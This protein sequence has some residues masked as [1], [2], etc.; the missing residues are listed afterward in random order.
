[1]VQVKSTISENISEFKSQEG[2]SKNEFDSHRVLLKKINEH[3]SLIM[4]HNKFRNYLDEYIIYITG[5]PYFD[6]SILNVTLGEL[7]ND[8][9][10]EKTIVNFP[11]VFSEKHLNMSILSLIKA[12]EEITTDLLRI[13]ENYR[14]ISFKISIDTLFKTG[15]LNIDCLLTVARMKDVDLILKVVLH[16][17]SKLDKKMNGLVHKSKKMWTEISLHLK[18]YINTSMTDAPKPNKASFFKEDI[19]D[20]EDIIK[21]MMV[22][23][24]DS[25]EI[26]NMINFRRAMVN[27]LSKKRA[28]E[29]LKKTK[30]IPIVETNLFKQKLEEKKR[31]DVKYSEELSIKNELTAKKLAENKLVLDA[32]MVRKNAR[33]QTIIDKTNAQKLVVEK[34][35]SKKAKEIKSSKK[36]SHTSEIILK[37]SEVLETHIESSF[38]PGI[39]APEPMTIPPTSNYTS[40]KTLFEQQ[41][42][43]LAERYIYCN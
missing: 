15:R 35:T 13:S 41:H 26:S 34:L 5:K 20:V 28:K 39:E 8:T 38:T 16:K 7:K 21:A 6:E 17:L 3:V 37:T 36:A 43:M 33:I 29:V 9:R 2:V 27:Q 22:L 24:I 10:Y 40:K 25:N 23:N 42:K 30:S 1:M 4:E 32:A 31:L 19:S 12:N 18:D 11:L 14:D